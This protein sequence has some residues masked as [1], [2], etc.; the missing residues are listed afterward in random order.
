MP[1]ARR[2]RSGSRAAL[3]VFTGIVFAFLILPLLVVFPISVS[4][5]PYLQ[6]PPPGFSWQWYQRYLDDPTWIEATIRSFKV[7]FLCT[8]L[9]MGLGVPLSFALVRSRLRGMRIA[10]RLVVRV[11]PDT[12]KRLRNPGKNT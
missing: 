5:A 4:S 10:D 6:F 3:T 2:Q 9:S 11:A 1:R 7:A 12:A 8:A